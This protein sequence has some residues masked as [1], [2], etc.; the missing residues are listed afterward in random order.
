MSKK[1]DITTK[2][3]VL[4]IKSKTVSTNS[5]VQVRTVPVKKMVL[6]PVWF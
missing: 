1:V 2:Y 3:V 4:L 5:L 6:C